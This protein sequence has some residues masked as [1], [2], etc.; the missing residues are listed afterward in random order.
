MTDVLPSIN[1]TSSGGPVLGFALQDAKIRSMSIV[2]SAI[3]TFSVNALENTLN[4]IFAFVLVPFAN[5]ALAPGLPLPSIDGLTLV[6]P[7]LNILN[8]SFHIA[9]D[10]AFKPKTHLLWHLAEES[11]KHRTQ[12]DLVAPSLVWV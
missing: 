12:Q 1:G 8:N 2:K 5:K 9:S 3:G 4:Q 6:N 10:Y 7:T 11:L